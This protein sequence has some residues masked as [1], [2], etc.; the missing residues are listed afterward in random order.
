M[1]CTNNAV[2]TSAQRNEGGLK[3]KVCSSLYSCPFANAERSAVVF[4]A[5]GSRDF[6]VYSICTAVLYVA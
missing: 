6:Y 5:D 3:E 2:T 1:N 4:G